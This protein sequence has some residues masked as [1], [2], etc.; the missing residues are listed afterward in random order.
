[1]AGRLMFCVVHIRTSCTFDISCLH[2]T[3]HMLNLF[4]YSLLQKGLCISCSN[5]QT[6]LIYSNIHRCEE[7]LHKS[8]VFHSS[9]NKFN[10]DVS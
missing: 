3:T 4:I 1:M 8:F 2:T 6:Q 9:C 7:V 5:T 10:L